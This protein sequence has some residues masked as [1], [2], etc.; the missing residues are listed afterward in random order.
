M[1]LQTRVTSE[2]SERVPNPLHCVVVGHNDEDFAVYSEKQRQFA[3]R[4]AGYNEV[5][6]NSVRINGRQCTYMDLLNVILSRSDGMQHNLNT[7]EVPNLAVAYLVNF[8]RGKGLNAEGVNFFNKSKPKLATL[9]ACNPICVAIT[10]TYYV[11]DDPIR[12]V[13]AFIRQHNPDALIVVGGPR[14]YS[15]SRSQPGRVQ[16]LTFRSIGADI[17]VESSQGEATLALLVRALAEHGD[18]SKLPNLIFRDS[19]G[20]FERTER[21]PENNRLEENI[22]DWTR[23]PKAEFTPINYMRTARSCPFSCEFC[24]YPAMAGDHTYLSVD[25]IERELR[26]M[27]NTG[28]RDVI[29]IDDTFNVPFPRFKQ[30]CQMMIRNRFDFRWVSF[31]RCSSCD[32]EALDLMQGSGCLGVYLGIESGDPQILKNMHKFARIERY[33]ESIG[34]L[35]DRGILSLAS[36]IVGFPGETAQT[37]QNSI[38]FLNQA[39]PSFYNVQVY[40]HDTQAPIEK[41]R[42]RFKIIGSG[43]SWRH[44]TM[45]WREAIA[46]KERMIREVRHSLQLPLYGFSIWTV[47]Y[48]LNQGLSLSQVLNFTRFANAVS[49]ADIRGEP[50]DLDTGISEL[51]NRPD[52]R[53]PD[54]AIVQTRIA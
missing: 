1:T 17:Y 51:L 2:F 3:E 20:R 36:M 8:L 52:W 49:H 46:F 39:K 28:V 26:V 11:E 27:K 19:N 12:E 25:A 15:L 44:E 31:F 9:L 30:I 34:K 10:T 33:C 41:Q 14:I 38:D 18:L 48:L 6:T 13:I 50:F 37:V 4:S 40:Y 32:D 5:I 42:D 23:F 43:Y 29:F 22:I 45:D 21:K 35:T 7:F 24:N 16:D 53:W 47:P 54:R